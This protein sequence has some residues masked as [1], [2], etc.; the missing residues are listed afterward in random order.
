[1]LSVTLR[2]GRRRSQAVA[3]REFGFRLQVRPVVTFDTGAQALA[4]LESLLLRQ[5]GPDQR[6]LPAADARDQIGRPAPPAHH[7]RDFVQYLVADSVPE[8]VVDH[9]EVIQI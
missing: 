4:E 5:A 1:M 6:E 3:E 7:L 8:A 2:S 9:F